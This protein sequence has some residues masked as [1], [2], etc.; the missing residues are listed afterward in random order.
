MRKF[1][2][3]A[4][5]KATDTIIKSIVQAESEMAAARV[6]T[7]QGFVPLDIKEVDESGGLF[8]SLTRRVTTKDK[9]VFTRQLA[10]L[11]GAGLP[12]SQSLR[13]V[14]EQTENK[15]LQEII[16]EIIADVE[17]GRQLSDSF[18]KHPEIFD[19]I[20]LS[21]VT[22][23]EASGTLD[24]A[25]KRVASQQEKDAAMVSKIRGAMTYPAIVLAVIMGVMLF[26]LLVVVPQVE[27]L[28]S[29]MHK[30][31]PFLTAALIAVAKFTATFWWAELIL[32]VGAIYF[33]R[34]YAKTGPGTRAFDTLK[35]NMPFVGSMF[36][37]LYMARF[38]RTG[39][40]LLATGVP[41]LDM[42][43]ITA[44]GVNNTIIEASIRRTAEKV[45]GGR[46]LSVSLS[47][48]DYI[49]PMVPQMIKIG[50]QSGKIDEMMG[51]TAQVYE[52]ELDEE[53]RNIS[54]AIEPVLMVV[55][56]IVAGGM[57][58]AILFPIYSLV[59]QLT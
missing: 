14:L 57:V 2:Y 5:D 25:L 29:D 45:K 35:L 37:K 38:T 55:L 43:D 51:K 13:T 28:Y 7:E 33:T 8:G 30:T 12:L 16:Q 48:E 17:G 36:R 9:V 6:L 56:A 52:D 26:M 41:M 39:Q 10:T 27:K 15:K 24:Q 20:Y 58:A 50:E 46:A 40:T 47:R 44:T 34:Q 49:S 19:K 31:L 22:A 42:L 53:I 11:I 59:G 1:N 18:G 23:G 32:L 54:T 3:E 21:L 4:R